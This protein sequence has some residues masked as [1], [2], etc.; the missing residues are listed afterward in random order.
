MD[1]GFVDFQRLSRFTQARA[2]FIIRAKGN[3]DFQVH[4][5]RTVD[6]GTG[7]NADQSIRLGGVLTRTRYPQLLRRVSFTD[8]QTEVRFVFLTNNFDLAAS[9]IC[10]LYHCRWQVELFFKWIKQHLHIKS[11][12]GTSENAVKTQLWIAIS[13]Y[14]LVAI[15]RKQLGITRSMTEILQILSLTCSVSTLRIIRAREICAP[16]VEWLHQAGWKPANHHGRC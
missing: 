15:A 13:I 1:R 7:L 14:V 16:C 10:R 5:S 12:F 3:L 2:S 8:P 6:K 11:F 4:Q 9:T